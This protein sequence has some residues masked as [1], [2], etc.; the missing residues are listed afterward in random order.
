MGKDLA[1]PAL[2]AAAGKQDEM[3]APLAFQAK[4]RADAYD[5]PTI[6]AARMSFL[7]PDDVAHVQRERTSQGNS[8]SGGAGWPLPRAPGGAMG[9]APARATRG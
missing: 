9:G 6:R 5:L 3:A 4:V 8:P 1:D 2:D 7:Q